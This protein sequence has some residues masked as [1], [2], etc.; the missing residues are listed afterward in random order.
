MNNRTVFSFFTGMVLLVTNY[1]IPTVVKADQLHD[2]VRAGNVMEVRQILDSGGNVNAKDLNDA[3]TA[4][5]LAVDNDKQEIAA[6]LID[7][8]AEVNAKD[9]NGIAPLHL[10]VVRRLPDLIELLLS[11]G[12]DINIKNSYGSTPL[13][14]AAGGTGGKRTD[15]MKLLISKGADVN[16]KDNNGHTP[17]HL[18]AYRGDEEVVKLG[19]SP[20]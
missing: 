12:S 14:V 20:I 15:L 8:G 6:L 4:L 18:A 5:H 10:A 9:K 11:S 13:H 7:S 3:K 19:S 16:S 1:F 2:A 17:L